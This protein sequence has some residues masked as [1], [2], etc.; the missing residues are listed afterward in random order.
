MEN[1]NKKVGYING[2]LEGMDFSDAPANGKLFQAMA[3]LLDSMSQRV[4]TL[5]EVL[6]DLNDYVESI[7]DDL[8]LLEGN[9]DDFNV[10]DA[11][12]E[13][14]DDF[15]DDFE[16]DFDPGEDQL[17]LLHTR[18]AHGPS[19]LDTIPAGRICPECGK[20]F[21]VHLSDSPDTRYVCP[22]CN[23]SVAPLPITPKNA[24]IALPTKD[25]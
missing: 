6:S 20:L 8:S 24:P 25:D 22:H 2:L 9:P 3:E 11:D 1:L 13:D 12:D 21:F 5:E 4:E 10:M 19:R 16:D 15:E 17:H 7:D 23:A 18:S 14:Y